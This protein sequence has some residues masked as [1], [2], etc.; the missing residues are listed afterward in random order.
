MITKPKTELIHVAIKNLSVIW[1]QSQRPFNE[2]WA[3]QIAAE[4]DP[5]KFDPPVITKPNGVGFYHIVE[6][7][8]RVNG[9]KIA[10]GENEQLLCRMVD[11]DDPARAAEIWLGINSGR[12]AIR[13]VQ[14]FEVS[15]IASRMPEMEINTLVKKMGYR[16]SPVRADHCISA[17][18]SLIEVHRK[19]G[20]MILKAT[21]L[22]IDKT[23]PG[24]P[25][26][27]GGELIKGYASFINEFHSYIDHKRL[28]ENITKAFTPHK[29][30]A[31]GRL[32]SEQN[33]TAVV[34]GI[35]ETI[36][37]KYNY[38]MRD[39]KSKLRRK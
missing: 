25:A 28:A 13:P 32:Y 36:R 39:E 24:D 1:A 34:E 30:L 9:A 21:L 10:F 3:K 17:V 19:F 14:R 7:Q 35:A 15:V 23:W 11:A 26:A 37:S 31:A 16:I 8:H 38:K 2:K 33:M 6:G 4:F 5:D 29:L 18:S 20:I 12:K 27:F 22:A